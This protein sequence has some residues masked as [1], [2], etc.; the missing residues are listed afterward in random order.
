V[1]GAHMLEVCPRSPRNG[2]RARSTRSRSAT[3]TIR[4]GS[5]SRRRPARRSSPRCSTSATASGSC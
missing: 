1:L 5:S 2:P 3:G 4:C